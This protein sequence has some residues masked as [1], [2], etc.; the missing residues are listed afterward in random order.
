[1]VKTPM[2]PLIIPSAEKS[3]SFLIQLTLLSSMNI[4]FGFMS[5]WGQSLEGFSK[6]VRLMPMDPIKGGKSEFLWLFGILMAVPVIACCRKGNETELR[7]Q[8]KT[9]NCY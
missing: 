1:M 5:S 9:N 2:S 3:K 8:I 4:E 6:P 7:S